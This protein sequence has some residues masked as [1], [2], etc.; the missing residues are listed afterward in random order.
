MHISVRL[1]GM[2]G[3]SLQLRV[4]RDLRLEIVY[5]SLHRSVIAVVWGL[6]FLSFE[7]AQRRECLSGCILI[8]LED[9]IL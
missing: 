7:H 2:F 8:R 9:A 5:Q 3:Q 4:D 1:L 6:H